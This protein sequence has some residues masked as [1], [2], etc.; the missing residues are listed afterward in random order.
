MILFTFQLSFPHTPVPDFP[1]CAGF[2]CSYCIGC[3]SRGLE[4][5]ENRFKVSELFREQLEIVNK[6]SGN[7]PVG[8][9]DFRRGSLDDPKFFEFQTKGVTRV[10]FNNFN[11]VFSA[12]SDLAKGVVV[13]DHVVAGLFSKLKPG[14]V[15]V[16]F[17]PLP[18]GPDQDTTN[19]L[20]RTANLPVSDSASFFKREEVPLGRMKDC[21]KWLNYTNSVDTIKVYKYTRLKQSEGNTDEE[22][23]FLCVNPKCEW[24]VNQERIPVFDDASCTVRKHCPSCLQSSKTTRRSRA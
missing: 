20:R 16:S 4:L 8:N 11:D 10:Y 13:P 17:H 2:Y 3:D 19:E 9:I 1:F 6:S 7:K 18:L 12:R 15:L 21:V 22:A 14:S 5:V 23:V 24:A